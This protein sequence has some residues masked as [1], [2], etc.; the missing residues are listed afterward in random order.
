M[1]LARLRPVQARERPVQVRERPAPVV[2][3]LVQVVRAVPAEVYGLMWGVY[4]VPEQS[5][6]R[7]D[8][9]LIMGEVEEDVSV[10]QQKNQMQS[11]ISTALLR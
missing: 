9:G 1:P 8:Q 10:F 4:L 7:A 5:A 11:L 6:R 3:R 2:A